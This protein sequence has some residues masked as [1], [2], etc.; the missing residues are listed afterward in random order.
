VSSTSSSDAITELYRDHHGW[1]RGWLRR[2]LGCTERAAD[3]AHDTFL[4]LL[5]R[6]E[7]VGMREPRAYLSTIAHGLLVNHWRRQALE[8]AY[9]EEL[10]ARPEA[11]APSEEERHLIIE[12]LQRVARLIDGLPA[13]DREIFLLSQLDGLTYPVIAERLGLSLNVVQKAMV[14]ATA[15]CYKALY[16]GR[17]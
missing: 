8:Q 10:A 4:R 3:F 16:G 13:R 6:P 11:L 1:L 2:R 5:T 12:T 9:L 14:R 17:P 7:P 15:H